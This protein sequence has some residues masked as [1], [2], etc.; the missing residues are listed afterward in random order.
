MRIVETP[1]FTEELSGLPEPIKARAKKQL[2]L[3]VQN[4]RHPSL[5]TEKMEG[6]EGIWKGRIT[7]KY[8]F[9]FHI[10][11]DAYVLRRIGPHDIERNP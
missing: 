10:E 8:R 3:F 2:A 9:T 11:G 5:Q 6:F 1:R 7:Q 4:P